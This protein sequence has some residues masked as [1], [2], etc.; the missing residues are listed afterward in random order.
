MNTQQRFGRMSKITEN[1]LNTA[2]FVHMEHY[3]ISNVAPTESYKMNATYFSYNHSSTNTSA[4]LPK[5]QA[6]AGQHT[7]KLLLVLKDAHNPINNPNVQIANL[8]K[9]NALLLGTYTTDNRT[10]S[11]HDADMYV[12]I[13]MSAQCIPC[14]IQTQRKL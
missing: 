7:V 4:N 14:G 12:L 2:A 5:R 3:N 11:H 6:I 10:I 8:R 9:Q 1:W 13:T